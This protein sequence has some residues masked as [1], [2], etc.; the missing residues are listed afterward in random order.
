MDYNLIKQDLEKKKKEGGLA[1]QKKPE[2]GAADDPY[3]VFVPDRA[4][5]KVR[6]VSGSTAGAGSGDFHV[7]RGSRRRE[8]FRVAKIL[9][10]AEQ[11]EQFEAFLKRKEQA[12][13][14]QVART[15]KKASKRK[16]RKES[17]KAARKKAKG[18]AKNTFENDG[19]FMERFRRNQEMAETDLPGDWAKA[20]GALAKDEAKA[21]T[22]KSSSGRRGFAPRIVA[23]GQDLVVSVGGG[24]GGAGAG[25]G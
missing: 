17:R 5:L 14:E 13:L 6:E 7:Y 9:A 22:A 4:K 2:D 1:L 3:K 8:Q 23:E 21:L 11:K 20:I 16:R 25:A 15:A 18:T 24:G 19:S 10:E 12:H